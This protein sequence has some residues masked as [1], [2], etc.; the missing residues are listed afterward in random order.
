MALRINPYLVFNGNAR[1][2]IRFYQEALGARLMGVMTYGETP[3]DPDN[4]LPQEARDL[5]MH[6]WLKVGESDLMLADTFPGQAYQLGDQ[7][8]VAILTDEPETAQRIFDVLQQGGKVTLPLQETHWSPAFG[9]VTDK[10]GISF[11]ISTEA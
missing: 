4:P 2:A 8:S 7:A 3:P 10:F 11:M 6:A 1:E 5:V 9:M